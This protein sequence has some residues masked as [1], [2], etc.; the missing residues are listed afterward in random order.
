MR[1]NYIRF[2]ASTSLVD[3]FNFI[4]SLNNSIN[5]EFDQSMFDFG[6]I[7]DKVLILD[8]EIKYMLESQHIK[9]QSPRIIRINL[10]IFVCKLSFQI[11]VATLNYIRQLCMES[12]FLLCS[13][14]QPFNISLT[15]FRFISPL[16]DNP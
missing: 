14:S 4:S 9:T 3:L 5:A 8:C 13:V 15:L 11:T 1:L 10:W 2:T 6:G 12:T 16:Y 7:S